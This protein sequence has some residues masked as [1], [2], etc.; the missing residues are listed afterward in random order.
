M[1]YGMPFWLVRLERSYSIEKGIQNQ[2]KLAVNQGLIINLG[3]KE[4]CVT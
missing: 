1:K 2:L 3:V 4:P